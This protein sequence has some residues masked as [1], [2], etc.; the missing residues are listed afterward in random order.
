MSPQRSPY[1]VTSLDEAEYRVLAPRWTHTLGQC[2]YCFIIWLWRWPLPPW[3]PLPSA[4][5]MNSSTI[6]PQFDRHWT[7]NDLSFYEGHMFPARQLFTMP[8]GA[9][10]RLLYC[11]DSD[12][13]CAQMVRMPGK[14]A[15]HH[16]TGGKLMMYCLAKGRA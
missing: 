9:I 1:A 6:G 13:S 5:Q 16:N 3:P 15:I 2:S 12:L 14:L 8:L 11:S 10:G 4:T 7:A